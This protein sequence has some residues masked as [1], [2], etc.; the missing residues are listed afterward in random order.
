MIAVDT[1]VWVDFF[2]GRQPIADR[3][4]ALLDRDQAALPVPVRVEILSGARRAERPRLAR[5]LS[6]L[7]LLLPTDET[8]RQIEAWVATGAAAG[9]RFG[10]ADLLIAAIAAENDCSVWSED[11]DF[12]RLARLGLISLSDGAL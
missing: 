8:W 7:P 1:S 10:V 4:S 6:A 9:H 2:R 3:T 11:A 5:L 12:G